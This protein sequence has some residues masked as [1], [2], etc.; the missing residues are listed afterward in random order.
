MA[1]KY[2][3]VQRKDMSKDAAEGAKKFYGSVSAT[4]TLGFDQICSS[5][6]AYSTASP[7]DVKLVLDGLVFVASE[8]LLRG[9]VVQLGELG[10]FQLKMSSTGTDT[11]ADYEASMLSRPHIVFRPSIRLKTAVARVSVEKWPTVSGT[12]GSGGGEEERP[13]EL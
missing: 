4:G 3:L 6:S 13:G 9:E 8:A 12:T 7:G 10:N 11:A 5:I 1:L 2:R